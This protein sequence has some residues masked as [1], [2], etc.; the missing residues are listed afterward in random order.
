MS[1]STAR[2]WAAAR[3]L[4]DLGDLTAQWL[5]GTLEALPGG[6]YR[7]GPDEET[8]PLV[9]ALAALNRA[10]YVTIQSQPGCDGPAFDGRRWCQRAAVMCLTDR[11]GLLRLTRT[12]RNAGLLLAVHGADRSGPVRDI[13]VTTWGGREQTGFGDRLRRSHLRREYAGCHRDAV[14]AV[15]DAHQVTL[16]DPQWGRGALLWASLAERLTAP[17]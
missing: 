10:G 8:G 11:A 15:F 14:R 16:V 3:T 13:L 9:P 6:A 4:S 12:A 1:R 17:A 2:I 7:G 5:E